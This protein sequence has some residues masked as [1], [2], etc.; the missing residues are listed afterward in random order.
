MESE[1]TDLDFKMN[2]MI[3]ICKEF[4]NV[5]AIYKDCEN[6]MSLLKS[7]KTFYYD[8]ILKKQQE[9]ESKY[10][11]LKTKFFYIGNRIEDCFL[12]RGQRPAL[13]PSMDFGWYSCMYDLL[14]YYYGLV[15]G[16]NSFAHFIV[17]LNLLKSSLI[18]LELSNQLGKEKREFWSRDVVFRNKYIIYGKLVREFRIFR[19]SFINTV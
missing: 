18:E 4:K 14:Y 16:S 8:E 5:E 9:N 12:S 13:R 11:I 7:L 15:N 3:R 6:L 19:D 17:E 1:L 10:Q 2:D